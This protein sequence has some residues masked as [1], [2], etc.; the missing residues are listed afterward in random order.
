MELPIGKIATDLI[1]KIEEAIRSKE[2][3]IQAYRDNIAGIK[4]MV[5]EIQEFANANKAPEAEE[6]KA[7]E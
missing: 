6:E 4:F 2:V 3:E 1:S 5:A 7:S